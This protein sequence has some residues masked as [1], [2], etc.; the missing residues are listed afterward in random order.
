MEILLV[1]HKGDM[2]K[3]PF[4]E[5]AF[6]FI[7]QP[8]VW[9]LPSE[10]FSSPTPLLNPEGLFFPHELLPAL[11][12]YCA[13]V[14]APWGTCRV[15]LYSLTEVRLTPEDHPAAAQPAAFLLG[16]VLA[17][18]MDQVPLQRPRHKGSGSSKLPDCPRGQSYAPVRTRELFLRRAKG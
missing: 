18:Q 12:V 3:Q 13:Y 11:S 8:W 17:C 1:K 9:S 10:V 6:N 15:P 5:E 2:S 14:G 4:G 7:S 16:W